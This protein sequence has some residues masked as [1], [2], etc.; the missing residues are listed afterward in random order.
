M[1]INQNHVFHLLS[2]YM[3]GLSNEGKLYRQQNMK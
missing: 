3:R 1:Q 2:Y